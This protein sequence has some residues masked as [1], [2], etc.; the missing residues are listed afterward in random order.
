MAAQLEKY[1]PMPAVEDT[2]GRTNFNSGSELCGIC[3]SADGKL[4]V[5]EQVYANWFDG[6][7]SELESD[8]SWEKWHYTRNYYIRRLDTDR[9][10]CLD[11]DG[12]LL[13]VDETK[14]VALTPDGSVAYTIGGDDYLSNLVRLRDGSLGVTCWGSGGMELRLIDTKGK[15]FGTKFSLPNNAYDLLP[16]G[17]KYDLCYR[18]GSN[19]YG[20]DLANDANEKILNWINCDVNGDYVTNLSFD[21]D[22]SVTAVLHQK[23][24]ERDGARPALPGPRKLSA[25]EADTDPRGHVPALRHERP[26]HR[27]QP[28]ERQRP[29]RAARL[30]GV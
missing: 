19:L 7:P 2:E 1:Q 14:V 6:K 26:H 21:A 17:G 29:H 15:R 12:N 18:S 25:A 23:R 10:L 11:E 4:V 3:Q 9:D 8:G 22:G 28:Q 5:L 20:I 30:L 24:K 13:V 16:G 27:L